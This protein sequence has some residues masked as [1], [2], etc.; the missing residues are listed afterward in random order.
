M[1]LTDMTILRKKSKKTTPE[2]CKQKK[3][4]ERLKKELDDKKTIG[5]GLAAIQ[6]GEPIR[7]SILRTESSKLNMINPEILK[8]SNPIIFRREGCLSLPG[9]YIDT[10]RFKNITVKWTDEDGKNHE[11]EYYGLDS[12]AI[13][14]EIDHHNAI[15]MYDRQAPI[16]TRKRVGRKIGR[17]EKCKK[18]GA[19]YKKHKDKDH[20]FVA[21]QK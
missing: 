6:I 9:K 19:K 13:Q 4:F 11:K 20:D 18:C 1:I 16:F 5:I 14:H 2:E 17:N 10:V 15:I 7:A 3:I 8:F 12:I 21:E